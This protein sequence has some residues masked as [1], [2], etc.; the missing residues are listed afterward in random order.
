MARGHLQAVSESSSEFVESLPIRIW[1]DDGDSLIFLTCSNSYT[2]EFDAGAECHLTL[3]NAGRFSRC[4]E[5]C[6]LLSGWVSGRRANVLLHCRHSPCES[7][8]TTAVR[9]EAIAPVVWWEWNREEI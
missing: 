1:S 8:D 2:L 7:V 4:S 3:V 9:N 5:S 6:T